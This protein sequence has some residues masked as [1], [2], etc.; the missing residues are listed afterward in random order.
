MTALTK[1]VVINEVKELLPIEADLTDVFDKKINSLVGGA[2]SKLKQEGVD[3][4]A[5]DKD[6]NYIFAYDVVQNT[7][8]QGNN[9]ETIVLNNDADNYVVCVSYQ[10]M[11]DLDYDVDMDFMTEQYITR[12]GTIRCNITMRQH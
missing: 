12:I 10:L 5:K 9:V 1:D 7:N 4:E 6:G 3:I 8:S 11:K 2:I